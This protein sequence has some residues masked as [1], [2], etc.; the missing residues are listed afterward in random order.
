[1]GCNSFKK[2][3]RPLSPFAR[4]RVLTAEC[5]F[6]LSFYYSSLLISLLCEAK[7]PHLVACPWGSPKTWDMT[8]LS[9]PHFPVTP[10]QRILIN[11]L[12]YYF[13]SPCFPSVPK[14]PE[15]Q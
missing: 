6:L 9:L 2:Y 10:L 13:A 8:I 15:L 14:E 12:T 3:N 1:M 7:V 11:P 4:D 5:V